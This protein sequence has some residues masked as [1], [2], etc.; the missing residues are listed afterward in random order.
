[1]GI[2]CTVNRGEYGGETAFQRY[3]KTGLPI[4]LLPLKTPY[5]SIVWSV[6]TEDYQ[7]LMK[8]N[9]EQFVNEVNHSFQFGSH[10]QGAEPVPLVTSLVNK[11]MAFPLQSL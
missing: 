6:S 7:F 1:M 9:D 4:A 10:L 5:S 11:R 8:L 2:V 3:L